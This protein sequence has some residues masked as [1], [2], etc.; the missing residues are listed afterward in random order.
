MEVN[1]LFAQNLQTSKEMI[2]AEGISSFSLICLLAVPLGGLCFLI[3][4]EKSR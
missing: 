4:T 3:A 1:Q 2:S